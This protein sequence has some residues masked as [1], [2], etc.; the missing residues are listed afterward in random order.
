MVDTLAHF[1]ENSEICSY[2]LMEFGEIEG[3]RIG[4]P[5]EIFGLYMILLPDYRLIAALE[6]RIC[7]LP[8]VA[9]LS[10]S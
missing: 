6:S 7:S 10:S 8:D 9:L 4:L 5:S 1:V 3:H 2:S